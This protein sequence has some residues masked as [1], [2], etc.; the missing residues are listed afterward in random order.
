MKK[1]LEEKIKYVVENHKLNYKKFF[2][3]GC[4]WYHYYLV[5]L[6][7]SWA[8]DFCD[9]YKIFV[10]GDECKD[11]HIATFIVDYAPNPKDGCWLTPRIQIDYLGEDTTILSQK[12]KKLK[13]VLITGVPLNQQQQF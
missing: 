2:G 8:R 1:S 3:C 7:L 6:E 13:K 12:K 11:D 4:K 9:G 10:Y 5:I